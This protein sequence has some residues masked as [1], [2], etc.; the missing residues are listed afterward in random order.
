MLRSPKR[1]VSPSRRVAGRPAVSGLDTPL[2]ITTDP[3][4]E[5]RSMTTRAPSGTTWNWAWVLDSDM[6]VERSGTRCRTGSPPRASGRRP[7]SAS[8]STTNDSPVSK[9]TRQIAAGAVVSTRRWV[10]IGWPGT[11]EGGGGG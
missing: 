1:T 2:R 6:S 9:L 3:F 7:T 5:P 4:V 10:A 8:P 11:A